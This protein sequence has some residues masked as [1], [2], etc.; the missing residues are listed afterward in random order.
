MEG[1]DMH[2]PP[3]WGW[4]L[5]ESSWINPSPNLSTPH[6]AKVYPGTVL[7]EGTQLSEGRGTTRALEQIG[8]PFIDPEAVAERMRQIQREWLEGVILRPTFFEPTFHKFKGELCRGFQFHVDHRYY[9]HAHFQPYRMVCL[10]LK[11]VRQMHP[12][13]DLWRKPPYEYE[14]KLPPIDILSGSAY[15]RKWVEDSEAEPEDLNDYLLR[16]E[17]EWAETVRPHLIY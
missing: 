7:I 4:P 5:L 12:E 13:F 14:E 3:G 6:S 17:M 15:L 1:Y 9:D 8:A 16:D 11:V 10:F 2:G